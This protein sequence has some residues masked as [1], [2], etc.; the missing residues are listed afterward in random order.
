MV[1]T[2]CSLPTDFDDPLTLP[3]VLRAGWHFGCLAPDKYGM[4]WNKTENWKHF[5]LS[6]TLRRRH[7]YIC[8]CRHQVGPFVVGVTYH[9]W[10]LSPRDRCFWTETPVPC[11]GAPNRFLTVMPDYLNAVVVFVKYLDILRFLDCDYGFLHVT[12]RTPYWWEINIPSKA[13]S[14]SWTLAFKLDT[15]KWCVHKRVSYW[16]VYAAIQWLEV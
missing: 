3:L 7:F 14:Q 12:H 11:S 9:R 10:E 16:P 6:N 8:A 13:R 15:T 1:P 5:S 2:E 4:D